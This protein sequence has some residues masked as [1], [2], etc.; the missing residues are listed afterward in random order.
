MNNDEAQAI[1]TE[2]IPW[3]EDWRDHWTANW[4]GMWL[5][6]SKCKL[7]NLWLH[8]IRKGAA[9]GMYIED[10]RSDETGYCQSKEGAMYACDNFARLHAL[11][12]LVLWS[13]Y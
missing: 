7:G 11:R 1:L 4:R 6:A 13:V 10:S 12:C 3:R 2:D 9:G 8:K 5:N